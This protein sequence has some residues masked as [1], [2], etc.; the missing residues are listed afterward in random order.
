MNKIFAF[1]ASSL[2]LCGAVA[3]QESAADLVLTNGKILTVDSARPSAQALAV[4]GDRIVA[5]GSTQDIERLAT[6]RTRKIDLKGRAVVPGF[7]DAHYHFSP[8]APG[9]RLRLESMDPSWNDVKDALRREIAGAP[10]GEWIFGAVG[11]S[12]VLDA[13]VDRA[14]LDALSKTHP[15]LLQAYYGHG[16][17]AN[18]LA[19][20]RLGIADGV[21]DPAGGH[22]ER[23]GES[24]RLNGRFWEYAQWTPARTL[25]SR[26]AEESALAG[27]RAMNAEAVRFGITSI[28]VFS[29]LPIE[30]FAQLLRKSDLDIRVRAIPF[31]LTSASGRDRGEINAL[32]QLS[33]SNPKLAF[34]GVKWVLDGTPFEHGAA[35]RRDYADRPGRRGTLNFPAHEIDAMLDE[36]LAARQQLLVHAVGDRTIDEVFK[37]MERHNIGTRAWPAQR[38]RIEHGD[39]LI[40]DLIPRARALGVVVVQNP[41]HFADAEIFHR[42][43]G[44]N[45][46][47]LRSL[48]DAGVRVAIGSDGAMNPFL[49]VM[50]ATIHPANPKEA[51]TRDQALAAYTLGAAY[52]EFK[53]QD[54]GSLARGKL[55]DIAVLSQ[56]PMTVPTQA[57]PSVRSVLTIIGGR[58]V[59]EEI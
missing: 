1:A 23:V 3:A 35:L 10:A 8:S 7:N 14:A 40:D 45:M 46:Q 12:V 42:R 28:Q 16:Y 32:A 48:L 6:P 39:G 20:S 51:L 33:T 43:W 24:R 27:L 49:N 31:S 29:T 37:A 2:L 34:S 56:D 11:H 59:H 25:A 54:K 57:L 50:F 4:R 17:I 5:V 13:A 15:V 41:T 26:A 9:R 53:E 38:L 18:S 21:A 47:P 58:I 22:F 44:A 52:A 30:R 36:T 55:A 19:L